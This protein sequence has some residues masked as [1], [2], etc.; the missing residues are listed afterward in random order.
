LRINHEF[1]LKRRAG[2]EIAVPV[3]RPGI[4]SLGPRWGPGPVTVCV[5]IV[6]VTGHHQSARFIIIMHRAGDDCA[7]ARG[8]GKVPSSAISP[9]A[10]LAVLVATSKT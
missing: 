4:S 3:K 9:P 7:V 6:A 1:D 5:P 8:H 2:G 10:K